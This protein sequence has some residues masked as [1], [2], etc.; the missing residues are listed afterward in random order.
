MKLTIKI[1]ILTNCLLFSAFNLFAQDQNLQTL[2]RQVV[3]F[4]QQSKFDEAIPL[5]EKIVEIQRRNKSGGSQNL[6]NALE[7]LAQIELARFKAAKNKLSDNTLTSDQA[8]KIFETINKDGVEI[9]THLREALML[10]DKEPKRDVIQA[11]GMRNSLA[12]L[13]SY[14]SPPSP[15]L[16][17]GATKAEHDKYETW[18]RAKFEKRYNDARD[19]YSKALNDSESS[20]GETNEATLVTLLNFAEFSVIAGDFE[21]AVSLYEKCI[22]TV[23]KKYGAENQN[24]IIP[25]RAYGQLLSASGQTEE[26]IKV[27]DRIQKITGKPE[28]LSD[29][30]L[31]L[32]VRS[33][34]SFVVNNAPNIEEKA[35]N[36]TALV[37]L[38]MRGIIASR[39]LSNELILAS[40]SHGKTYYDNYKRLSLL[41]IGVKITVDENGKVTEAEALTKNKDLKKAAE[42]VVKDWKF[43]PFEHNGKARKLSGYVECLF[44]SN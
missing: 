8:K 43:K 3:E 24:L 36:T 32:S 37:E 17:F 13:L 21:K 20:F 7:N 9:E 15:E 14:F 5:A 26:V 31:N 22:K 39:N 34:K 1:I 30:Y 42:K 44:F 18:S 41:S 16:I 6:I 25:L 19:F 4:Y 28:N 12:W 23:E 27:N 38:Q 35:Q 2:S 11:V 40:S 33:N 10:S 29:T